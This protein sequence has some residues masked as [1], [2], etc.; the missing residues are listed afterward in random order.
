MPLVPLVAWT[1]D[2]EG[3]IIFEV[4]LGMDISSEFNPSFRLLVFAF[5]RDVNPSDGGSSFA[6]L[7]RRGK[8]AAVLLPLRSE[9]TGTA[10]RTASAGLIAS[11]AGRLFAPTSVPSGGIGP[12]TGRVGTGCKRA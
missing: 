5:A 4:P 6:R 3:A 12:N 9:R 2:C 11:L 10:G 1:S 7:S 8:V